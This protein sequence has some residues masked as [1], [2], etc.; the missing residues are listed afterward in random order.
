MHH[1]ENGDQAKQ[2]QELRAHELFRA[3]LCG[4]VDSGR[5]LFRAI[6]CL[7]GQ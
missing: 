3:A 4:A 5:R 2:R 6:G 7:V 1:P